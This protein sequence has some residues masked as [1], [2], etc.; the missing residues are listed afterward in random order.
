VDTNK[1]LTPKGRDALNAITLAS[2][3]EA[4]LV[5]ARESIAEAKA[6]KE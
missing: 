3:M 2:N 1:T 6:D 4:L 5:S